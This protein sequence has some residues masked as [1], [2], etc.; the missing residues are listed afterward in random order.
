MLGFRASLIECSALITYLNRAG[1]R[2]TDCMGQ[3]AAV[4]LVDRPAQ[5]NFFEQQIRQAPTRALLG[6]TRGGHSIYKR[7][8]VVLWA[9]VRVRGCYL[10]SMVA[11]IAEHGR[12]R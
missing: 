4:V 2:F 5:A 6:N 12:R 10:A 9:P 7:G 1:E 8:A 11:M 3:R